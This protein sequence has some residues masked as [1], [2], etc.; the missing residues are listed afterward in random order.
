ET[1]LLDAG[2]HEEAYRRF[3]FSVTTATTNLAHFR[4]LMKKYPQKAPEQIL[5]DLIASTPEE[6]GRWFATAKSLALFDLAAKLAHQSPVNIDTLNRAARDFIDKEPAFALEVALASLKWLAAGEFYEVTGVDVHSAVR[7]A[8]DASEKMGCQKETMQ[9]ISALADVP[10]ADDFVRKQ[11]IGALG[12]L[13]T[14][15]C[16]H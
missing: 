11:I 14:S 8:L 9:R 4:A 10:H 13:P 16:D 5:R 12:R 7:Y 3:A 1:L 2:H 15:S 6:E